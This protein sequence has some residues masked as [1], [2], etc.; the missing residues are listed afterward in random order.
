MQAV[1]K[2]SIAL[3]RNKLIPTAL[4]INLLKRHSQ[5]TALSMRGFAPPPLFQE[6]RAPTKGPVL[7]KPVLK[8]GFGD[9]SPRPSVKMP[10]RRGQRR[11]P[12]LTLWNGS[13][14]RAVGI[15][16]SHNNALP[17]RGD[18]LA[19]GNAFKGSQLLF[20]RGCVRNA[21]I[22]SKIAHGV[23]CGC[24]VHTVSRA[25]LISKFDELLLHCFQFG[26]FR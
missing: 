26:L 15:I 9:Q 12:L 6:D 13:I 19:I 2:I 20:V 4:Y 22:L 17:S 3:C 14:S 21:V 8:Q 24:S 23:G 18:I 10:A 25:G 1:G 5:K 16:R 11:Q 7:W